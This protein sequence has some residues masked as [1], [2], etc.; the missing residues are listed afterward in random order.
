LSIKELFVTFVVFACNI[1]AGDSKRM[2]DHQDLHTVEEKQTDPRLEQ[3]KVQ[4]GK[5]PCLFVVMG[6]PHWPRTVDS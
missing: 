5:M 2:T 1:G 6:M 4:E 3:N